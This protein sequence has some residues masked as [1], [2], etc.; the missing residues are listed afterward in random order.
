MSNWKVGPGGRLYHPTT[1][2]YVGQLDLNGNEQMVLG[3]TTTSDQ[4]V[5]SSANGVPIIAV[6]VSSEA[7]DA[8][9][10]IVGIKDYPPETIG[11]GCVIVSA[12]GGAA[13][14]RLPGTRSLRAIFGG[15]DNQITAGTAG[16][17]GGLACVIAGS[18]HSSIAGVANHC[19]IF[20]GSYNSVGGASTVNAYNTINGGTHNSI[21]G[22]YN[23][24]GLL[25]NTISGG[26]QNDINGADSAIVGGNALSLQGKA[27]VL[28][29]STNTLTAADWCAVFGSNN[30]VTLRANACFGYMNAVTREWSLTAGRNN[31]N[32]ADYVVATGRSAHSDIV[33]SHV[34][35]FATNDTRGVNQSISY[36]LLITT[37]DATATAMGAVGQTG[38]PGYTPAANTMM[39]ASAMVS[40]TSGSDA[41]VWRL[42]LAILN[43]AGTKTVIANTAS[44][45]GATG[46]AAAWSI[47]GRTDGKIGLS[48]TGEAGKT[49]KWSADV[50]AQI[51]EI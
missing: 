41:K 9:G 17:S 29:G 28:G 34:R 49:I 24:A 36:P 47:A 51:R 23:A 18:H 2:A 14:N 32:A 48:V 11:A 50:Q 15:Y 25:N 20:G 21:S 40:A 39:M 26:S 46:G 16:D 7:A 43:V 12:Y 42:D 31:A 19:S 37:T 13:N 4:G 1:G 38:T 44:A 8:M 45:L 35:G 27:S 6:G 3:I 22:T 5:A 10:V 30:T 33:Y